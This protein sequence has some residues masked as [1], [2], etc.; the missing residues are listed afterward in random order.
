[1]NILFFQVRGLI[2]IFIIFIY[3]NNRY[4]NGI[5][6]II[7]YLNNFE[8]RTIGVSLKTARVFPLYANYFCFDF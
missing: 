5:I 4:K 6:T 3:K 2:F 7:K 8:I 1:M